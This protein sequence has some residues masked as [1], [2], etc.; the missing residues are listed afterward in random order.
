MSRVLGTQSGTR[1]HGQPLTTTAWLG[2][3]DLPLGA[4]GWGLG[5]RGSVSWSKRPPLGE[6]IGS[7]GRALRGPPGLLLGGRGILSG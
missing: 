2:R 3:H 5:S 6:G 7:S 4:G 1:H